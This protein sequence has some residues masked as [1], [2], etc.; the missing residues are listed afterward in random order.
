MK[1]DDASWHWDSV[2]SFT[3]EDDRWM[4]ACGHIAVLIK[5]FSEKG[6]L[7][8]SDEGIGPELDKAKRGE[9]TYTEYFIAQCDCKFTDEDLTEEGNRFMG[10]YNEMSSTDL[11]EIADECIFEKRAEDYPYDKISKKID[12]RYLAWKNSGSPMSR[13]AR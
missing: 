10:Y 11:A 8:A 7:V 13:H 5:W 3:D 6:L 12:E 2:K 9:I 4:K 1:Y